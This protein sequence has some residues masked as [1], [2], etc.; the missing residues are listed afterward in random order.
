MKQENTVRQLTTKKH[1]SCFPVKLQCKC[2]TFFTMLDTA[3]KQHVALYKPFIVYVS[4]GLTTFL[5]C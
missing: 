2:Q 5:I 4:Q 1:Q 3:T